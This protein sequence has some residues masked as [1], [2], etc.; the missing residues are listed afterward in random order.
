MVA[1]NRG[2]CR[3]LEARDFSCLR[4]LKL[5]CAI[6]AAS[7]DGR[8]RRI[9]G[10]A[11]GNLLARII[12]V[13]RS[14]S[15][16][17]CLLRA[18][19]W[20]IGIPAVLVLLLAAGIASAQTTTT[21]S[22]KVYDPRTTSSSLP[23]PN[24]LVYITTNPVPALPSGVQCLTYQAP[25]GAVSYAYSDVDGSFTIPDVPVSTTYTVVIQAGK[26]RRQFTQA[27][28]TTPVTGLALHMPADHTQGDIPMIAIATGSV[29]GA[30]CVLRDMGISDTE[31]TDD[32]GSV[33]AS[34]HIHYYRGSYSAGAQI[35]ASTPSETVLMESAT[36]LNGY[37]MVMFPC[38]GLATGQATASRATNL[39]NYA[40]AGGRVFGTHYS[41]AW[42]V[43]ASPFNALFPSVAN[44]TYS[45]EKSINT[46]VGTIATN[47]SDGATLAQWLQNSGAT[48]AGTGNQ[49]SIDTLRTDVGSVI[50]PTQSWLT[51]NNGTYSG[52]AISNTPVMQ[53][54]FNTP[55]GA[56]AAQQCGRVMYN[57][58]HVY[59]ISSGGQTFPAECPNPTTHV[60]TA[61]EKM[62]EYALFDLS[63]FV[64]P[65]VVPTLSIT[66]NPSP[67]VVTQNDAADQVTVNVTNTS[68]TTP[69]SSSAILTFTMPQLM[70]VTSMTDATG[71]W[72]CTVS[73]L[74][75]TR[76]AS[77]AGGATDSVVLTVA[78]GAYPAGGLSSYTGQIVA[79]VS[80]VTFSTN[81][82]GTD[83]VIYRQP[84]PITWANPAPIVFGTAL[85][86]TQLNASST[87]AGTFTYNPA[88]GTV[89]TV[90][91][92]ALNVSFAPTDT[93]NYT[94]NTASVTITVIPATPSVTLTSSANPVF[95]T[96]AVTFSASVP[97]PA[98]TPGGSVIF[99][100]GS[101][102]IGT[103]SLSNGSAS[104]TTSSLTQATHSITAAYSGD[105]NYGP[106]T[107]S[108]FT[109]VVE[110]FTLNAAGGGTVTVAPAKVATF[111]LVITP[112]G[113]SSLPGTI[114]FANNTLP[115]GATGA[116]S[117]TSLPALSPASTVTFQV[118]LPGKIGLASPP[119]LSH[120]S[121]WP[122]LALT[123][124]LLPLGS[125]RR[126]RSKLGVWLIG[127]IA[128][129]ALTAG[130]SGCGGSF[131][132][133]TYSI[134]V[135][136]ASGNLNHSTTL[137]LI[138]R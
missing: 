4:E 94:T 62:L 19:L 126:F 28:D 74:S 123:L 57:D 66:F 114:S 23:I 29:D 112:V 26:W 93:T 53:M 52:T 77:L 80:S 39:F 118:Q 125:V 67:L 88:A 71:N 119:P 135:T 8:F 100:D 44:W 15:G 51:L 109:E 20:M 54:T 91:Q 18:H 78:V 34:G 17:R 46:G 36:L 103:S 108:V 56:P 25:S 1:W 38:Q 22:G 69:T 9:A 50:A 5:T 99:Y 40:N 12:S 21:I 75:C 2:S 76:N 32:N 132:P 42:L 138:V 92:H 7:M 49:I 41:Y 106:A 97:A 136:A 37:D 89:L 31:F 55:V 64:Q 104:F 87:V 72:Q 107:S 65:V 128:L 27:V 70:T 113:G 73:T 84:P 83:V 63:S 14:L 11:G 16:F 45:S 105:S 120:R 102:Q 86:A 3:L 115:F 137:T 43:P 81:V 68:N 6:S 30:E 35:N 134:T 61:Q 58:Y 79:T 98:G 127:I 59:N 24:V 33:N 101:T 122:V 111:S 13:P 82:T 48:V 129:C 116:F 110:D 85:S 133:Q 47:F 117:P 95:L 124:L 130:I 131:T 96:T 90:G 121:S 10:S 60:M